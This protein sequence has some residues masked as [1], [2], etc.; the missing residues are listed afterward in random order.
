ML[1]DRIRQLRVG[2]A[3]I[4]LLSYVGTISPAWA[5]AITTK[6]AEPAR[7]FGSPYRMPGLGDDAGASARGGAATIPAAV[8]AAASEP[9]ASTVSG[10]T[11]ALPSGPATVGGSGDGFSAESSTGTGSLSVPLELQPARGDVQPTLSLSY[12]TSGGAGVAGVG[13]SLGTQFI[14]RQVDRGVPGYRDTASYDVNQDRFVLNGGELV[15]IGTVQ[16]GRVAGAPSDEAMPP[17]AEGW[18]YFRPR[19]EGQYAR[20]FW[21]QDRRTWRVQAGQS[22]VTL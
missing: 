18:Q 2:V 19:V 13:W 7:P 15:P 9:S 5:S 10:Q 12:S 11:L 14:A 20:V 3:G 4:T 6:H 17:W 22:G 1:L 16:G 21:S 8:Q